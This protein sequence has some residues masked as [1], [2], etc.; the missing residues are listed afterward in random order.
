M[1]RRFYLLWK[2]GKTTIE[3]TANRITQIEK[4]LQNN[5]PER[6]LKLGFSLLFS[7]NRIVKSINQL[8]TGDPVRIQLS[9]GEVK[10]ITEEIIKKEP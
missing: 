7:H 9:D 5:N 6:Q 3:A 10:A 2:N 1:C 8:Q 4:E